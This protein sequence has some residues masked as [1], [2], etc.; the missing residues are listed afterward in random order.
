MTIRDT[1][2]AR[3][4]EI[5]VID[6]H[7]H[8]W[9]ESYRLA[10]PGDWTLPFFHYGITA[11]QV[12]GMTPAESETLYAS[13]TPHEDKWAIF[14]RYY[15]A[16]RNTAYLRCARIALRDL[17]GIEAV[18]RES[19]EELTRRIRAAVRPGFYRHVLR[20]RAGI[21]CAWVNA[22]DRDEEGNRYPV[23]DWGDTSLLHPALFANDLIHP[24][25]YGLMARAT[26][27]EAETLADWLAAIDAYF[28][29]YAPG[30]AAVKV[31][32]AY[33]RP[34]AY[35]P[36]V[37]RAQA[38]ALYVEHR[39]RPLAG[40]AAR[41]L[42]DYILH[43]VL[44][45]A[46]D[47]ALP[48]QFHTGLYSGA[49]HLNAYA[50]RDNVRDLAALA[51]AHPECRIIAMH[52]AYPFQDELVMAARQVP[53]LFAEMSWAWVVDPVAAA[54]FM[55]QMLVAAPMTKLLGFGG[56]YAFVENTYGHLAVARQGMARALATL[57]E[58]WG[59]DL[60]EAVEAG[61]YALRGSAEA[62]AGGCGGRGAS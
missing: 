40:E 59:W 51:V 52:I 23:R 16:A 22:F 48:V 5:R 47:Y 6:T 37:P 29:R 62:L 24:T 11:L 57:V 4:A 39:E 13:D 60:E 32:L 38:E 56:D 10:H 28:A 54:R 3:L 1:L 15:P 25:G 2:L 33:R 18:T 44:R 26:G 36:D 55:A 30:C 35:S 27:R 53:N 19:M 9:D 21:D 20:E 41:P 31:A 45:R 50:L 58:D 34:L 12:A 49:N 17:Y 61:W 7:E 46:A 42:E 43:H 14:S 8:L